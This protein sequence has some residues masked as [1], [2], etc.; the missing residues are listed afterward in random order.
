MRIGIYGSCDALMKHFGYQAIQIDEISKEYFDKHQ[1]IDYVVLYDMGDGLEASIKIFMTVME[2]SHRFK[3]VI[4]V[5]KERNL[6]NTVLERLSVLERNTVCLRMYKLI[7]MSDDFMG[8]CIR[9]KSVVIEKD[10]YVDYFDPMDICRVIEMCI[11]K[12]KLPHRIDLVYKDKFKL[13]Q[14]AE[15]A[16]ATYD[17]H[18]ETKEEYTGIRGPLDFEFEPMATLISR[19]KEKN[20]V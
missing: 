1:E 5:S 14:L 10:M 12:T 16:G 3:K 17:V 18:S 13:S 20:L 7:D 9:D 15:M 19:L 11:I 2:L 6:T 8:K 4:W